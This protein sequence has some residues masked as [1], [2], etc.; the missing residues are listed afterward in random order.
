MVLDP[1]GQLNAITIVGVIVVFTI[2]LLILRKTFFRPLITVMEAR[3]AKIEEGRRIRAE[4][5]RM[6]S[7]AQLEAEAYLI[8]AAEDREKAL[9]EIKTEA[10]NRREQ[11]LTEANVKASA[12]LAAGHEEAAVLREAE[13]ARMRETLTTCV[14]Q[15]LSRLLGEVDERAVRTLVD[16]ELASRETEGREGDDGT[17]K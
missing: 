8:T 13:E 12:I 4:A 9:A 1:I 5:A 14:T 10:D 6:I 3:H 16:R 15:T 2:V 7:E 17:P 11:L